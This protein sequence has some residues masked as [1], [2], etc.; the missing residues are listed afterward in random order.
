[1]VENV[2]TIERVRNFSQEDFATAILRDRPVIIEDVVPAWSAFRSWT[3]EY[4]EQKIGELR[5]KLRT[6]STH[7]HPD[8]GSMRAEL[9]RPL[10]LRMLQHLGRRIVGR[11]RPGGEQMAFG[12]F[13]KV[14][15]TPHG[16]RYMA[17]AEEL[18]ILRA[19]KWNEGLAV[20][21]SDY[22][23]P[24]YVP[25][26]RLDSA[27]LWV[28]AKG[29]RTHLHYDGNCL[30]NLNAQVTG[31]KHVQLYSPA[32]MGKVYPYLHANGHPYTFSRVNVEDVDDHEFPLF[33][34]LEEYQGTLQA[35]DLLFIPAYWYHTFKHLGAFN[36]N[37]NFWWRADFVRLTPVSARDYFGGLAFDVL[38]ESKLPQLW[39]VGWMR[40]MERHIT[41]YR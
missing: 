13:L 3:P 36:T 35:G 21:R 24:S 23:V 5:I 28:S 33:R 14:L 16:F 34:E 19:G 37:I 15:G 40:K 27:A 7:I 6:S 4:L 25:Q 18:G 1:M 22:D 26:A 31:S 38:S 39:L 17:G 30:H 10:A 12:D 29:V 2:H 11:D 41:R 8:F 20:L 32:Q 9:S